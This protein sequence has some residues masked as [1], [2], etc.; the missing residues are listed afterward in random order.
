LEK[1]LSSNEEKEDSN[2]DDVDRATTVAGLRVQDTEA[3]IMQQSE[4]ISK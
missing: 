4:H 2:E 3:M 1:Q